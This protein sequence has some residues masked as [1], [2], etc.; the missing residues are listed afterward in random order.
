[1]INED[2]N[3]AS[4]ALV[5]FL[6]E[7]ARL[8]ALEI[9]QHQQA[10]SVQKVEESLLGHPA[11]RLLSARETADLLQVKLIISTRSPIGKDRTDYAECG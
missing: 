7:F 11:R 1:M 6:H 9:P 4:A 8:I 5:S 10:P 2:A 3:A